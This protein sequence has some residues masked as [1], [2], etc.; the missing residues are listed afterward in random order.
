LNF[1][2]LSWSGDK[3]IEV[4]IK[5]PSWLRK[6]LCRS[7]YFSRLIADG[8]HCVKNP[9]AVNL[10]T[11]EARWPAVKQDD[12]CGQFRDAD[13]NSIDSD[14]WPR[15]ELPIYKDHFGD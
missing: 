6:R 1:G 13:D 14:H 15:N 5:I 11:G 10:D 3:L 2:F 8:L 7:C 4:V 9:P 12:T